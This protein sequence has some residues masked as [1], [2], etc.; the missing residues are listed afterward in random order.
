MGRLGLLAGNS[1]VREP[2]VTLTRPPPADG[3]YP[4]DH[5]LHRMSDDGGPPAPDPARWSD[6]DW[7]DAEPPARTA[8]AYPV[9]LYAPAGPRLYAPPPRPAR[10]LR[11]AP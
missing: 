7:R 9:R 10:R 3:G 5:D 4:T 6:A 8:P 2:H 1:S 11:G